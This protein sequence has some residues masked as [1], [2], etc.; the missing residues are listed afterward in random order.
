MEGVSDTGNLLTNKIS[1]EKMAK[2]L[3]VTEQQKVFRP[4][5]KVVMSDV[6]VGQS[7]K[8]TIDL[9]N[10]VMLLQAKGL[11]AQTV[12]ELMQ[13][14]ELAHVEEQLFEDILRKR[15]RHLRGEI[16]KRLEESNQLIVPWG[17]AHMPEIA[18]GIEEAGFRPTETNE[19]VAIRFRAEAK[20]SK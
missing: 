11:D 8:D 13:R 10:L 16:L 12:N 14:N 2:A 7:S 6:D 17:A 20:E 4:R 5:G 18:K 9:L 1:Y 3:G 19:L 15:N